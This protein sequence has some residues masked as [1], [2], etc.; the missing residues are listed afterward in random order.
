LLGDIGGTNARFAWQVN[1]GAAPSEVASYPCS[2]YAT[3][4]AAVRH[5]LAMHG[6]PMPRACAIAIANPVTGDLVRM[7]NHHWS[8]SIAALQDELGLERLAVI[9]DFTAVALSLPA[10]AP[11]DLHRIGGGRAVAGAALAVLGPGTGLGVSG[12]LPTAG[13]G[14]VPISGEGGHATLAAADVQ[15]AAIIELLRERHGHASAERALS[16]PGLVALYEAAATLAGCPHEALSP[17]DVIARAQAG[18]DARCVEALDLFGSFLG[19]VAGNL[20][21]TLGA[22]G[23]VFIAGGMAPRMLPELVRSRFRQR[24]EGKGRFQA[25]LAG[26]PTQIVAAPVSP[27]FVGAAQALDAANRT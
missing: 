4:Q 1:A 18:S 10:L 21:L 22:R 9:N 15:E 16:G 8:F 24:F 2:E 12:L 26:I 14:W 13:G 17:A 27:A 6:K 19:S 25:Y 7:T 20:A 23:G 11:A 3:L 5:Y